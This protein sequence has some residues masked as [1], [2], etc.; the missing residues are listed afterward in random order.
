[1]GGTN[2]SHAERVRIRRRSVLGPM[3][4]PR[5]NHRSG[6][7]SKFWTMHPTS[8]IPTTTFKCRP[9]SYYFLTIIY[10]YILP[11]APEDPSP[12]LGLTGS[13]CQSRLVPILRSVGVVPSY[14]DALLLSSCSLPFVLPLPTR[15]RSLIHRSSFTSNVHR[16]RDPSRRNAMLMRNRAQLLHSFQRARSD[17]RS[18]RLRNQ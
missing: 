10:P 5:R 18:L 15:L 8:T 6:H 9:S 12:I 11:W 1:M 3:T 7:R 13:S 16:T 2:G 4:D 14:V 17:G